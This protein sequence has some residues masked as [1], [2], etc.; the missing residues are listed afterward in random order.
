[1]GEIMYDQ[2]DFFGAGHFYSQ[3]LCLF[4][5]SPQGN[6]ENVGIVQVKLGKVFYALQSH[7]I[8]EKHFLQAQPIL[9]KYSRED[10]LADIFKCLGNI[11]LGNRNLA[12]AQINFQRAF[13][14]FSKIG[15]EDAK[16][17]C[18]SFLTA[19]ENKKEQLKLEKKSKK[20]QDHLRMLEVR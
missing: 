13:E 20:L 10:L 6:E 9:G 14:I 16:N 5:Q 12:I 1:M 3:A 19:I 17:E 8:A 18:A 7:T 2:K 11:Y 15:H 4:E